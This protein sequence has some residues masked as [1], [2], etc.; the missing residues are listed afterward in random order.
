M[1]INDV[2]CEDCA[3]QGREDQVMIDEF[4]I[5]CC[6]NCRSQNWQYF[7]AFE[8]LPSSVRIPIDAETG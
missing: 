5:G 6:P 8:H 4:D 7:D 2:Y 3:W 1:E